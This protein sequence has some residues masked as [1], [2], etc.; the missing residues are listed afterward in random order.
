MDARGRGRRAAGRRLRRSPRARLRQREGRGA[1]REHPARA[2]PRVRSAFDRLSDRARARRA[3]ARSFRGV[4]GR[5][6]ADLRAARG[7]V[8]A[9]LHRGRADRRRCAALAAAR[10]GRRGDARA[11]RT[12]G[13]V[14]PRRRGRAAAR[15]SVRLQRPD[16]LLLA[17]AGRRGGGR[18][19]V[20]QPRAP[21]GARD[22][23][24]AVAAGRVRGVP[25]GRAR[26]GAARVGAPPDPRRDRA[27]CARVRMQR[28]V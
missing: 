9:Q 26:E 5:P 28:P 12:L 16:P 6:R 3:R 22:A 23:R 18:A 10:R 7:A 11:A 8:R 19:A 1:R 21:A 14:L 24:R 17:A 25:R 15:A 27:L 13:A 2:A 4:E 20:R